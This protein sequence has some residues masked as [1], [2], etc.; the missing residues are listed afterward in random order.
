MPC[1]EREKKANEIKRKK[2]GL[3]FND[4]DI[5]NERTFDVKNLKKN[6]TSQNYYRQLLLVICKK[7]VMENEIMKP[8][9]IYTSLLP[10]GKSDPNE[11]SFVK[12]ILNFSSNSSDTPLVP[13]GDG[14]DVEAAE[15]PHEEELA[16][17]V[18]RRLLLTCAQLLDEV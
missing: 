8:Q 11:I 5:K 9:T 10:G 1:R 7:L 3:Y 4:S 12:S 6:L 2:A 18:E 17:G 15:P 16:A 13:P 14:G